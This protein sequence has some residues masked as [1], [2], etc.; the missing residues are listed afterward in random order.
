MRNKAAVTDNMFH[1]TYKAVFNEVQN[2]ETGSPNRGTFL[3]P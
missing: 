2:M 3:D 1:P